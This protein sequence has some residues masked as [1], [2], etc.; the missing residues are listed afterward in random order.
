VTFCE[1]HFNDWS[2]DKQ[3]VGYYTEKA[4]TGG[5]IARTL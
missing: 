1:Q 4:D 3:I 5:P 2:K